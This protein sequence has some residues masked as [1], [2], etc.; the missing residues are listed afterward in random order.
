MKNSESIKNPDTIYF[1][2]SRCHRHEFGHRRLQRDELRCALQNMAIAAKALGLDSCIVGQ[3][4]YI[5]QQ[6]NIVE[7]NRFL[8]IPDG[9]QHD[10]SICFGYAASDA[11]EVKPRREG[12][13]DYIR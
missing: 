10:A 6:D 2:R 4:R 3:S 8:K 12:I 1:S 9:Y 7:V 5:Y 13:V 11:P